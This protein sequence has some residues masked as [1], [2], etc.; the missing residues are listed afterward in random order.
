MKDALKNVLDGIRKTV[1]YADARLITT[2]SERLKVKNG[3]V[4]SISDTTSRGFGIRV[5]VD[6]CWGF[7]SSSTLSEDEAARVAQE[8]IE[9]ARATRLLKKWDIDLSEEEAK[10]DTYQTRIV[11]NP[12]EVSLDDKIKILLEADKIM[13]R[14]AAVKVA[15]GSM[16]FPD[17]QVVPEHRGL[18]HRADHL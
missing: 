10:V 3:S 16:Q 6:G 4:D 7:S 2:R 1:D 14:N 15:E 5:I 17:R 9:I 18:R 13:R 8:A 11:K 12:F